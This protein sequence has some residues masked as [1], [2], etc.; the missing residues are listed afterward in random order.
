MLL[1]WKVLERGLKIEISFSLMCLTYYSSKCNVNKG[2]SVH[3]NSSWDYLIVYDGDSNVS[4]AYC[5]DLIPPDQ[6]LS[7][8]NEVL[9]HFKS[10]H[11]GSM[12]GFKI[13]YNSSSK[14]H[15][16]IF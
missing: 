11:S 10:D 9:I 13:G 7:S 14:P 6:I 16:I 12:S 2:V 5:G 8:T 15:I 3:H 1:F 4:P